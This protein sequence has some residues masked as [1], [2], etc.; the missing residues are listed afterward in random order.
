[1]VEDRQATFVVGV[2]RGVERAEQLVHARESVDHAVS[3][4]RRDCSRGRMTE[5]SKTAFGTRLS[6]LADLDPDRA[7]LTCLGVTVSRRELVLRAQ[8]LAGHLADLGVGPGSIVTIGVP[9]SIEFV[10]A[11]LA[12][13]W[14]GATAQPI[15]DRLAPAERTA[16]LDLAEP[17]VAIGV[18]DDAAGT[19]PVLSATQVRLAADGDG[20]DVASLNPV[21]SPVWRIM[22]SGGSTGRPKLIVSN[23]PGYV[24]EVAAF[25]PRMRLPTDGAVLMTGPLAHSAPF[26]TAIT[27]LL[28]GNHLVVMPR[29]DAT[30]TLRLVELHGI[31]WLYLVPTMMLRIWR[32]PEAERLG[33]DVSSLDIAFHMA[34]PCPPWLKEAWIDWLGAEKIYELYG[35]TELQAMTLLY[36]YG[37]ART[38]PERRPSSHR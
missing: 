35:G 1:M 9:N 13:W 12:T 33:H 24:E 38:P 10:E 34:A 3:M 26:V 17:A 30:E 11:M 14:L 21:F 2:A 20:G 36:G 7:A 25:A 37:M 16:I 28:T 15:S 4:L 19:R 29:F 5:E 18:P 6:S 22:T 31:Q 8:R 32:L 27:S 23:Q